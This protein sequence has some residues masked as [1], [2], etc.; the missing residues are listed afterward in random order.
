MNL[1]V[2]LSLHAWLQ[3]HVNQELP[4]VQ[5]GFRK[6]RGT[7]DQIANICWIIE[8]ARKFQKKFYFCFLDYVK[9]FMWITTNCGKLLKRWEY[10]ATLPAFWETCMLVKKQQLEPDMEKWMGSKSG[11]EYVKAVYCHPAYST[12]LQSTSCEILDWMKFKLDS[13]LPGR[14][15][16]ASDMPMTTSLWEKAKRN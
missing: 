13:R 5:A 3:Q 10:Q 1:F 14:I 8:K 12:Y 11:K 6:D 7:R 15:S 9:A 4:D 16:I 2:Y